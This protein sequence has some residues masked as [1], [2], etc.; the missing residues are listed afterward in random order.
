MKK[1]TNKTAL[2]IYQRWMT[3]NAMEFTKN[4]P[5]YELIYNLDMYMTLDDVQKSD[6]SFSK[7]KYVL[8]DYK[9]FQVK[10]I[11]T[12]LENGTQYEAE[13][14]RGV[15]LHLLKSQLRERNLNKLL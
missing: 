2:N 4:V 13:Y 15:L 5:A 6:I 9:D 8:D 10:K 3:I 14:L 12:G 1:V 11:I 7:L